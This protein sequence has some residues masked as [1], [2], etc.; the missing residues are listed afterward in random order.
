MTV[1]PPFIIASITSVQKLMFREQI[2]EIIVFSFLACEITFLQAI[3]TSS[4]MTQVIVP[5][6]ISCCNGSSSI[7]FTDIFQIEFFCKVKDWHIF[8]H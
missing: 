4:R 3:Y 6:I 8:L 2:K 5:V 1:Y 7:N